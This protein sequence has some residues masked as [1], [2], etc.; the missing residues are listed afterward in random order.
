VKRI[1]DSRKQQSGTSIK[2]SE[3]VA[4]GKIRIAHI[5][6][7]TQKQD[8][9]AEAA[10]AIVISIETFLADL[11][12]YDSAH[13]PL[14]SMRETVAEV[15]TSALHILIKTWSILFL[16][17]PEME[18]QY[19]EEGDLVLQAKAKKIVVCASTFLNLKCLA[20]GN[21]I[22]DFNKNVHAPIRYVKDLLFRIFRN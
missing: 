10:L 15:F 1:N 3:L 5:L 9:Q 14:L 8:D 6:K 12:D 21:W 20:D 22:E 16:S 11:V 19:M 13:V 2:F 17:L 18:T 4:K 7:D